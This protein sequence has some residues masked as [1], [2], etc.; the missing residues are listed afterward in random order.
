MSDIENGHRYPPETDK[1]KKI[2][3]VLHLSQDERDHLF[4]LAGGSKKNNVS[5]DLSEYIMAQDKSRLAL[6]IARDKGAGEKEWEKIIEILEKK[7][8]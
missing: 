7:A 2:A 4:D 6:R 8:E 1:I 5:P 3:E